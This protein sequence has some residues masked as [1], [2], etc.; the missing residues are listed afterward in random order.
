MELQGKHNE[1]E[2]AK[3]EA[4]RALMQL[5]ESR[6]AQESLQDLRQEFA[7]IQ[8]Q[9]LRAESAVKEKA[10]HLEESRSMMKWS[11]EQLQA[12]KERT[13][14]LEFQLKQGDLQYREMEESWRAKVMENANMLAAANNRRLEEL[15][16]V[17]QQALEEEQDKQKK[18]RE[19][20]RKAKAHSAKHAQ[21]YDEMVLENETLLAQFE[22]LKVNTMKM[23]RD[24]QR[25]A[26]EDTSAAIDHMIRGQ[27]RDLDAFGGGRPASAYR[28]GY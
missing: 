17:H 15:A 5:E 4:Q 8:E 7:R 9:L 25:L 16:M 3:R 18:L 24:Q 28:R 1:L 6:H 26:T 27:R 19:Q 10:A 22:D 20:L 12:E 14:Q 23:Y 21:R 13:Q 2:H 11:N